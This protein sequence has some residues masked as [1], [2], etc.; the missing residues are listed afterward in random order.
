MMASRPVVYLLPGLLCDEAVWAHQIAALSPHFELRVPVFRGMN[1]FPMM[2]RK[3]LEDAP[4]RFSVIGH[5]MGGRVA[6]ELMHAVPERIDRFV[7]MDLGV[8]PVQPGENEERMALVYLA[9]EQG[10]EA[11]AERWIPPMI[12]RSRQG[13]AQLVGEIRAMVLR[14]TPADYR[15]QIEAALKREDQ[16]RYLPHIRH[17][18]LL[19][20]GEFDEWSPVAQHEEILRE[21]PDAELAIIPRAG[22]MVTMEEPREVNRVLLDWFSR[23]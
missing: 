8:H 6:M 17:R 19:V 9:E 23:S 21:L 3:V 15:G 7:V 2:A 22:H 18:A 14:H 1:S 4:Q 16:S 13:D 11:L 5:S 20:C 10:M 12:A